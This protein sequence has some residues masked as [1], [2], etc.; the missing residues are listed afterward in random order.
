MIAI[1]L[2]SFFWYGSSGSLN[3]EDYHILVQ[4]EN[5]L[6]PPP[7]D[8][9]SVL[10]YN[11]GYLSGMTNNL[12]VAREK[13]LFDDHLDKAIRVL[14]KMDVDIIGFQEIDFQSDRSFNVNQLNEIATGL[15]Y[16]YAYRSINWDKRYVPFPYWPPAIHF[17]KVLSGQAIV[18]R[19]P[20][21]RDTTIVLSKPL[22]TSFIYD[23]FY[24]DRLLQISHV[25]IGSNHL[26]VMNVHLEA[27]DE[28]TRIEQAKVISRIYREYAAS[29]PVILMGDFNSLPESSSNN[30]GALKIIVQETIS[31]AIS[32]A[33]YEANPTAY[34]TFSSEKPFQMIDYI[35]FNPEFIEMID[36][37]VLKEAGNISDHL[38]VLMKFRFTD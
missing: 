28:E 12:S 29:G 30:N 22:N 33:M 19:Y 21:T 25:Q 38:P 7:K 10:T 36:A 27:F 37:R 23:A 15:D 2:I 9:L 5:V 8:T 14:G 16:G 24:L 11:I 1:L 4:D 17:K 6:D 31:S 13:D 35:F 32:A 18:S 26:V 3:V 34:Y 20:I